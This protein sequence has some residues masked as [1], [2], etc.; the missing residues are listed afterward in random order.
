MVPEIL[1]SKVT[2]FLDLHLETREVARQAEQLRELNV[3]LDSQVRQ[4]TEE[5]SRQAELVNLAKAAIVVRDIEGRV[6]FWSRGAAEL[7]G[8]RCQAWVV[9]LSGQ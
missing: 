6:T 3:S 9:G 1:R 2:V 7:Y 4:R 5:L 8:L